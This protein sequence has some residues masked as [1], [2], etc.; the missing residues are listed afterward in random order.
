MKVPASNCEKVTISGLNPNENYV[1]AVAAFDKNGMLIGN[2]IGDST[3]PILASCTLSILMNWAFL[4][5]VS[6]YFIVLK[7]IYSF[8]YKSS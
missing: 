8:S 7:K 6:F 2:S 1:F 5:Q 4:C 3:E